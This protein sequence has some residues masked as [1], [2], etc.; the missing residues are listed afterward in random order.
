MI[1]WNREDGDVE[2]Q[3][4]DAEVSSVTLTVQLAVVIA[5]KDRDYLTVTLSTPF[6]VRERDNR[7]WHTVD[8]EEGGPA[9]GR[10]V[11][12]L[13]NKAATRCHI[14]A[15]GTLALEFG[16]D[17]TLSVPPDAH[18]EA[19]DVDHKGFKIVAGPGGALAIW[20]RTA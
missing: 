7:E 12:A 5:D 17:V 14:S 9:L 19:W 15:D 1:T 6:N 18:Y 8:P 3:L 10:L 13:R 16:G 2:I 11:V 4:S 20:D